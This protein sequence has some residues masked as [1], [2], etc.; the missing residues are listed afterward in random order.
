MPFNFEPVT[1][2]FLP[3]LRLFF[4]FI[5]IV[6]CVLLSQDNIGFDKVM[7]YRHELSNASIN[8][9][10][11][12]STGFIW[13]GTD[14]G[15]YR[16][17]GHNYKVYR[18]IPDNPKSLANN[19]VG[20]L[21]LDS[22]G[23]FWI[24]TENGLDSFDFYT[25][26]FS[27]Y[28]K[29]EKNPNS[30]SDNEVLDICGDNDGNLWVGTYY[31][32]LNRLNI[33]TGQFTSFLHVVG[34]P[35]SL[36]SNTVNAIR[37]DSRGILWVGTED[38]LNR[39]NPEKGT[40]THYLHEPDINLPERENKINVLYED[41]SQV[42]WA[43]TWG[44]GLY[45]YNPE[46]DSF[47]NYL[48]GTAGPHGKEVGH[49]RIKA[50][51][52]D[53]SGTLWIGTFANGLCRFSK[54]KGTFECFRYDPY[55]PRSLSAEMITTL[56]EDHDGIMWIGT[57]GGGLY[58]YDRKKN[59]FYY[60]VNHPL[61]R[62]SLIRNIVLSICED[63]SEPGRI[64]WIGTYSGLNRFDRDTQTFTR[65]DDYPGIPESIGQKVVRYIFIDSYN[66]LWISTDHGLF[67]SDP[68]T[69]K[70]TSF[71][72]DDTN[73]HSIREAGV[74]PIFEDAKK[75][76]W[77]GTKKGLYLFHRDTDSFSN[78]EDFPAAF[79]E[80]KESIILCI[81]EQVVENRHILWI[82]TYTSGLFRMDVDRR[83]LRA[84]KP[85][86]GDKQEGLSSGTVRNIYED[87]AEGEGILWLATDKGLNRFDTVNIK[88]DIYGENE[89]LPSEKLYG[90]FPDNEGNLWIST[91]N[92]LCC[93][94][95][96][97][98]EG[99]AIDE[100]YGQSIR[101]FNMDAYC[102]SR[103]GEL[104]FGGMN[105]L[106][107]FT[108][109]AIVNNTH[110]PNIVIT[111]FKILIQESTA[112]DN[113]QKNNTGKETMQQSNPDTDTKR[114][115][116]RSAEIM[117]RINKGERTI[118]LLHTESIFSIEFA[119]LD[120][121]WP[122]KNKYKYKIEEVDEDWIETDARKNFVS[123]INLS[124][125]TYHFTVIGSN[126]AGVW[127]NTGVSLKI[128]I[129]PPFWQTWWFRTLVGLSIIMIFAALYLLRV[130]RLRKELAE[131]QRVQQV[132]KQSHDIMEKAR[133]LAEYR[134]AE[135]EKLITAISSILI[136]VDIEGHISQW[137]EPAEKCFHITAPGTIG[138]PFVE[139]LKTHIS[140][141][142]LNLIMEKGLG[143]DFRYD[144]F[145]IPLQF[146][147]NGSKLLLGVIN[148]I[149]DRDGNKLGFLLLAE[150][151]THR[152]E[153]E[154]RR[155]LSQKLESLGK[156]IGNIAHEIKSPLQYIGN[157]SYF[158]CDSFEDLVKFFGELNRFLATAG[159]ENPA[160]LKEDIEKA[161]EAHDIEYILEEVPRA[162]DQIVKG[163]SRV[164]T[165]IQSML[166]YT[167]PG[168]TVP[169]QADIHELL[170]T[171]LALIR[172]KK[173]EL[174]DIETEFSENVPPVL[175]YP[176]ELLQVFMNLLINSADAIQENGKPGLI[177]IS[178]STGENEV[179]VAV[180]DNGCGI[181]EEIRDNIFNPFFTTKDVGKGTGQGLALVHNIITQRHK[182]KISFES[183]VGEGTTFYVHL[184]L[185]PEE[186]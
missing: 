133:N 128:I 81:R 41:R 74:S 118:E 124:P 13:F 59:D 67:R 167:H 66:M 146:K 82:G 112:P 94:N 19:Y 88:W 171:T 130:R 126:N 79:K 49:N 127:N 60:Y 7:A 122:D 180:T 151:I 56:Y 90:I 77:F 43:G 9:V 30:L 132:L 70:F 64:F 65:Y 125:G 27:H 28:Q 57:Y 78:L 73:P 186:M 52:E 92:G 108:P 177:R 34:N 63:P 58:T 156:M 62:D 164:S 183:R 93:F 147:D 8:T 103:R 104:L 166:D 14:N 18:N 26:T 182:G 80:L 96:K 114:Q 68:K 110:I 157:N 159:P 161:M 25:E 101:N 3:K 173:K 61:H 136:A 12:D 39:F 15:L 11:Q 54:E 71:L 179:I 160:L 165:I 53:E 163:V 84:Y 143:K 113:R 35:A 29:K 158:I 137:N 129:Y 134:R 178:T 24:G 131:Q 75:R 174:F 144:N 99:V 51:C 185:P 83:E 152:K 172:S 42:L 76:L 89:G 142:Q 154:M 170:E 16:F 50:L 17:D 86:Q 69:L 169:E 55:I 48:I 95:K 119:A 120:F 100:G 153:E 121:T 5:I 116:D 141:D 145:E 22:K 91:Q 184:P 148:P 38:G 37:L 175:C 140:P 23:N 123:Y 87:K 139:V 149:I 4:V 45:R 155:N 176:G 117:E 36:S 40:F 105:G 31:G 168:R 135:I 97:T 106:I 2:R 20:C 85:S 107:A 162:S 47:N 21:Y 44:N 10:L 46:T 1:Q 33:S 6:P 138:Q 98:R 72:P 111:D 102:L 109:G 115:K 181:P 32:G 150:D